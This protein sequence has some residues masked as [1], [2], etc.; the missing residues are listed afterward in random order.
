M[1]SNSLCMMPE[2]KFETWFME[3]TL[4][5]G[6]HYVKIADDF[7]DLDEKIRF[8]SEH[9]I[10]AKKIIKNANAYVKQFQNKN[11]EDY[12]CFKVLEQYAKRSGQSH[13]C[14]FE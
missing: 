8:Y 1:S 3:G 2:P 14:R 11:L 12:M 13:V 4:V 6:V 5:P 10:E 9:I 7:S